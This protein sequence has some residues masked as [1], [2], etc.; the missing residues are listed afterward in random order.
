M[1]QIII[2]FL[3]ICLCVKFI[4]NVLIGILVIVVVIIGLLFIGW[5]YNNASD[6]WEENHAA[7]LRTK[8]R[9]KEEKKNQEWEVV[10]AGILNK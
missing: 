7:S 8:E 5:I 9:K 10:K 4:P 3:V 2:G 6:V 1:W